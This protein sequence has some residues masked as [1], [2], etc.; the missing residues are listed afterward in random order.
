MRDSTPLPGRETSAQVRILAS[1]S[2]KGGL[3]LS[4]PGCCLQDMCLGASHEPDGL[5]EH[6]Q[7]IAAVAWGIVL[8]GG[9][10]HESSLPERGKG[11]K[12]ML[13]I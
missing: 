1:L 3:L 13:Y 6:A 9:G 4:L 5:T 11:T 7:S 12:R 10:T 2:I 8:W